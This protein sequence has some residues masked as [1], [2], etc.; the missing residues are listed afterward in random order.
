MTAISSFALA[1]AVATLSTKAYTPKK[2]VH[3]A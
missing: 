1:A 3:P 2:E